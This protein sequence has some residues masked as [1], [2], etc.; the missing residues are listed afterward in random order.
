MKREIIKGEWGEE[1][2]VQN[3]ELQ[4]QSGLKDSSLIGLL[5]IK[6]HHIILFPKVL[7]RMRLW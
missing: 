3:N 4:Q 7:L 6:Q 1:G 2:E 5:R